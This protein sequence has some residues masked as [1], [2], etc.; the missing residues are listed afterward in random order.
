M[1]ETV[2]TC[3][4]PSVFHRC[5]KPENFIATD[6][7]SFNHDGVRER[8]VVVKLSD[9]GLSTRDA[10]SSDM[11][12]GSAPYMN[13]GSLSSFISLPAPYLYALLC[14]LQKQRGPRV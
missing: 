6:G 2:A 11:D 4:A 13:Y 8:K 3:H 1:Y 9:F 14:R 12:C 5:I 10:A 7:W